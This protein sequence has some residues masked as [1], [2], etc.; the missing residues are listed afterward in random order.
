MITLRRSE[1]RGSFDFGWLKTSHTFSFGHY[2]DPE[3]MGFGPLRVINEDFVA[4]GQGFGAHPH[5]DME[6]I[7]YVVS[8]A[9]AHRD[10]LGHQQSVTPG[11]VQRMSAGSGIEHSEFN[12]SN[13]EPVHL[14]QIWIRPEKRG[15][16]PSY[17]QK[18]FDSAH[19]RG[20][21]GVLASPDA[22]EGSVRIGQDALML[23]AHLAP[24]ET[25]R[26]TIGPGRRAWVQVVKGDVTLRGG[27][28]L[29]AGDG[30][31]LANEDGF[32][33]AAGGDGAEVLVF[34]LP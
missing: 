31:G 11:E 28:R 6:I 16:P 22:R 13:A 26:H 32:D 2:R 27:E 34:D 8:G 21:L 3:W 5:S 30:A 17:E 1:E 4:P 24:G 9:L 33:L 19:T 23:G 15:E 25:A 18:R 12:P 14:L 10:S 7:T 20:R 29:R